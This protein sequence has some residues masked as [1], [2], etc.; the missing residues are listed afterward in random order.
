VEHD[1]RLVP[2]LTSLS[3]RSGADHHLGEVY[4]SSAPAHAQRRGMR[5]GHPRTQRIPARRGTPGEISGPIPDQ[6]DE[7]LP[8]ELWSKGILSATLHARSAAVLGPR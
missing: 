6:A 1:W 4:Q 8:F 3:S 5:K 7:D 2:R